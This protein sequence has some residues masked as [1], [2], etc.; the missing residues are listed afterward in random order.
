MLTNDSK[1]LV[2]F[3]TDNY[4]VEQNGFKELRELFNHLKSINNVHD[5]VVSPLK[6]YHN[7]QSPFI[8]ED[9]LKKIDSLKN[10]H[11]TILSVNNSKIHV[12]VYYD[13]LD[14]DKFLK[15]LSVISFVAHLINKVN[16]EYHINYYLVDNKKLLDNKI[17]NGLTHNHINSG[18]CGSN[19]VN[20]WR[21]EEVIKVTIHELLHLFH[22]DSTS[23]DPETIIKMYQERYKITSVAVNS[24]EAYTE[25]W[26]NIINSYLLCNNDYKTFVKNIHIEKSWCDL[27]SQKIFS[28][29]KGLSDINKHTNVLA[30]YIIR[31]ELF[32]H[33]KDF[34]KIFSKRICC[35]SKT[36]FKFLRNKACI[37]ND[38][39]L[40]NVIV[41]SVVYKSLR[42]SAIE[43]DLFK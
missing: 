38:K 15:I 24:F 39:I 40:K 37:E 42:M 22:C 11:Y 9:I 18:S 1:K 23:Q 41:R 20:I 28:V 25:I 7:L 26:A 10:N 2:R 30:Y 17:A 43:Y 3:V 32:K 13:T 14:I 27:Q 19:T 8:S 36:Y 4:N 12:N 34:I 5:K 21:K 6:N 31:C 16:G 33:L 35:N 29:N